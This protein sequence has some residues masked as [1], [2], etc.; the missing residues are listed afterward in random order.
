MFSFS[1]LYVLPLTIRSFD[2]PNN[3]RPQI[4][5]AEL[6]L[7]QI[8]AASDTEL[9]TLIG[10]YNQTVYL[11]VAQ[12]LTTATIP[13]HWDYLQVFPSLAHYLSYRKIALLRASRHACKPRLRRH[14]TRPWTVGSHLSLKV[15]AFFVFFVCVSAEIP[16]SSL[17]YLA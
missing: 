12:P 5:E 14:F 2:C 16:T 8:Q 6:L 11:G 4:V 13:E 9:D 3:V 7:T 10:K 1:S 17:L 15:F